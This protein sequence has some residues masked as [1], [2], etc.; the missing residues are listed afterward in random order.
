VKKGGNGERTGGIYLAEFQEEMSRNLNWGPGNVAHQPDAKAALD[1]VG[2]GVPGPSF[3][4]VT[5]DT[6]ASRDPVCGAWLRGRGKSSAV[7]NKEL[8][9]LEKDAH[10]QGAGAKF[11]DVGICIKSGSFW[12]GVRCE[13]KKKG[14]MDCRLG[15]EHG[16]NPHC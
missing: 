5:G 6:Y 9:T 8:E 13:R 15:P 12:M 11:R 4:A 7:W 3:K 14:V 16:K 1:F 10:P 2:G